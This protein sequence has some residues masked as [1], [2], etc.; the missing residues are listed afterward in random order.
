M[1]IKLCFMLI[2]KEGSLFTLNLFYYIC[3]VALLGSNNK[4]TNVKGVETQPLSFNI[5]RLKNPRGLGT[6]STI[7]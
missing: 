5:Q 7:K 2:N 4:P 3:I 6:E 1:L